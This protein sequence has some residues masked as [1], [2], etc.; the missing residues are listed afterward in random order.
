MFYR[1][2][3]LLLIF[4]GFTVSSTMAGTVD[5][6]GMTWTTADGNSAYTVND[7]N[8]ISFNAKDAVWAVEC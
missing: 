6:F 5:V 1:K 8:S 3:T 2:K 7:P 4:V